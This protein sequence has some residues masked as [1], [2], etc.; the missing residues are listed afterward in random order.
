MKAICIYGFGDPEVMRVEDVAEPEPG[1]GQ[2]VVRVYAAGVNPVDTYIRSG[3]YTFRP[4][5]PYTP[6]IDGAGIIEAVGAGMRGFKMGDR[7][8]ISGTVSGS[9]AE[10]T[11]CNKSQVHLLPEKISFAEGAAVGIPYAAAYR[12]LFH[13]GRATAGEVVLVHGASGGV[14][15][16]AVQLAR[17]GG[18]HVMGTAGT[19]AGRILVNEQGAEHVF[20]HR[21]AGYTEKIMEATD[22]NGVDVV[23]EMLA[24]VNLANDLAILARGGRIVV[25]G[26]QGKVEID[27]RDI[28]RRDATISG[29]MILHATEHELRGIYSAISAGLENRTLRPVVG[30]ELPLSEAARAHHEIIDSRAHGKIVLIP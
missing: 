29:M 16:A 11:L 8:Y 3:L 2:V 22:N 24:N 10:K 5:L 4:A 18:M 30:E 17:A 14:G 23:I 6:G 26:S 19:E 12:A 1:H 27:P 9:Y 21:S 25:V 28:M 13:I 15:I 7:V 20:D